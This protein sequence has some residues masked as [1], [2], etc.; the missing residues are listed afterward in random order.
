MNCAE[1]RQLLDAYTDG[2]LDLVHA[3]E[4]EK[5][6]NDCARCSA[7]E[8]SNRMLR[9]ALRQPEL[10]YRA[11]DSLRER[12]QAVTGKEGAGKAVRSAQRSWFWPA[13]AGTAVAVAALTVMLRPAGISRQD[14]LMQEAVGAHVRSLMAA[15]L[16]DVASSDQHTVKPWFDGKLDFAPE[17]RDFA[18]EGF[19]LIGGRLDYLDGGTVAA[20]V[21]Q[22][23]KHFINVFVRP[24]T[25]TDGEREIIEKF[26]GYSIIQRTTNGLHYWLVSD[27]NE[28]E[29][30]ELAG[31][32][33][34]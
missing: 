23:N 31:L 11:P 1:H 33:G 8:R 22:R 18:A 20:L 19:P 7:T 9:A 32:L 2:E 15:H 28:R 5:H 25:R 16:T 24:A 17:V 4:V 6:L 34:R 10:G 27:L 14:E 26:R 13:L 3:L 29:L 21:Y 30:G 12:M